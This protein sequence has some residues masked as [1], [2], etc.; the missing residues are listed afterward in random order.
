[1][2]Q[3]DDTDFD[4]RR[5]WPCRYQSKGILTIARLYQNFDAHFGGMRSDRPASWRGVFRAQPAQITFSIWPDLSAALWAICETRVKPTLKNTLINTHVID[6]CHT[7]GVKKVVA[8]GTA[9]MYPDPEPGSSSGGS[10]RLE[11]TTPRFG[12][13]LCSKQARYAGAVADL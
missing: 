6:A 13:W 4:H 2:I 12:I 1:M 10:G 11:R 7:A 9:A 8:M 5:F 3:R